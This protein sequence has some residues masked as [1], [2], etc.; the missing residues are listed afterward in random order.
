MPITVAGRSNA[1]T[2]FA[3]L[4]TGIMRSNPIGGMDVCLRLFCVCVVLCMGRGL[5][6]GCSSVQGVDRLYIRLR[7]WKRPRPN[8]G[9]RAIDRQVEEEVRVGVSY[10]QEHEVATAKGFEVMEISASVVFRFVCS[11]QNL[12]IWHYRRLQNAL[13]RLFLFEYCFHSQTSFTFKELSQ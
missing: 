13:L 10:E 8:K 9:C 12:Y 6:T 2:V 1:W 4:N 3:R 11:L 7:S 5:G